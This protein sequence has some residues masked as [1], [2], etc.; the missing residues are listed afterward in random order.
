MN[1]GPGVPARSSIA[2]MIVGPRKPPTLAIVTT[3]AIPAAAEAPLRNRAGMDQNGPYA[4]QWPTGTS[5]S[6]KIASTGLESRAQPKKPAPVMNNGTATC[7]GRSSVRSECA[8]LSNMH[9]IVN[10]L[11]TPRIIPTT[12]SLLLVSDL[13]TSGAQNE[14]P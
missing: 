2:P 3:N 14:Y 11:N 4:A 10:A 7:K 1:A 5:A 6:D 12:R 13:I 9:V 8:L